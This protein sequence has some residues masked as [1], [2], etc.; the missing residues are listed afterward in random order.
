MSEQIT[1]WFLAAVA[2]AAL[3]AVGFEL[4]PSSYGFFLNVLGAPEAGPIAGVPR[5]IRSDEWSFITPLFQASVRNK[6][7]RINET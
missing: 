6:F 3:L 7:Q 2:V 4:T 5:G 1:R